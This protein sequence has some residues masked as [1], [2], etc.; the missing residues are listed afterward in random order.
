MI[1]KR[2]YKLIALLVLLVMV[3]SSVVSASTI[4]RQVLKGSKLLSTQDDTNKDKTNDGVNEQKKESNEKKEDSKQEE[5][6]TNED[7]QQEDKKEDKQEEKAMQIDTNEQKENSDTNES[8]E[9]DTQNVQVVQSDIGFTLDSNSVVLMEASTGA[10]LY[11]KDMDK[12]VEP[13]SITKIMTML[14]IFEAID[15]GKIK[16]EDSVSV[17][18]HAASMGGSQVYLEPYETQTVN[19]LIKCI[20]IASAN[21]ACVAMAEYIA[22]SEEEFVNRMNQKAQELGM[23]NTHF[24]NSCGLDVADHYSSALD[25]ALMSRELITK[26]PEISNYS[27][28]WMDTITHTTKKG[29]S[30][31]GLTNTNK[32]VRSYKGITGLKTGSTGKA[33]YCLSASANRNGMDMIAV[34]MGNPNP[35]QRFVEA[36]KLLDYGFA[37]C[38]LFIDDHKELAIEPVKV[39]KGLEETIEGKPNGEFHYLCLTNTNP[40]EIKKEVTMVEEITAPIEEGSKLGEIVYT[41]NGKKIGS[42]DIV[43]V[44]QVKEAKFKDYLGKVI[45]KFFLSDKK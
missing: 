28:V 17:S 31:F 15:S 4:S 10:I 14:L 42:V 40:D 12:Q 26:H 9:S 25:V 6:T 13:A 32:L 5:K 7:S 22:G 30:E 1:R 18:E 24:V 11:S 16:L 39:K 41:Y 45:Q 44:K 36:A 43:A 35:L 38:S 3:A 37:N 8:T 23:K 20:S 34:V 29:T 33:K 2:L 21:D 27:T 19:D